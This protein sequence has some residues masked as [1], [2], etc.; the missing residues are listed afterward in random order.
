MY[1][2]KRVSSGTSS[3]HSFLGVEGPEIMVRVLT[4]AGVSCFVG[5]YA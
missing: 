5:V 4:G 1:Y 3:S 2:S